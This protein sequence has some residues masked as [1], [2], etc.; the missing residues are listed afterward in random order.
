M[1]EAQQLRGTIDSL[2]TE[3]S[4][5]KARLAAKEDAEKRLCE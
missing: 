2:E 3:L 5:V 1:E 4:D